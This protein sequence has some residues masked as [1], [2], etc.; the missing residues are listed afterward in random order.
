V[1]GA[2]GIAHRDLKYSNM[3]LTSRVENIGEDRAYKS[4]KIN[5]VYIWNLGA[6]HTARRDD[7]S[8]PETK[9]LYRVVSLSDFSFLPAV[10][11]ILSL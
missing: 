11:N 5:V 1:V 6:D 2:S 7:V 3:R 9:P 8:T 4:C 10:D